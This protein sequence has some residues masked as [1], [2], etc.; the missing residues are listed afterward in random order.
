MIVGHI[1]ANE[2]VLT[3][4]LTTNEVVLSYAVWV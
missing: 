3:L 4:I 1:T 2:V